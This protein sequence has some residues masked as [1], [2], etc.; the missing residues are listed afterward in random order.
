MKYLLIPTTLILSSMPALATNDELI[1]IC[2]ELG[3]REQQVSS[4]ISNDPEFVYAFSGQITGS[5]SSD[6]YLSKAKRVAESMAKAKSH[7]YLIKSGFFSDKKYIS[8]LVN[9]EWKKDDYH[10]KVVC[11]EQLKKQWAYKAIDTIQTRSQID[12]LSKENAIQ[13]INEIRK[14]RG[15]DKR[16]LADLGIEKT[17]EIPLFDSEVLELCKI[18]G[19][20]LKSN[21]LMSLAF[22]PYKYQYIDVDYDLHQAYKSKEY[23]ENMSVLHDICY[24]YADTKSSYDSSLNYSANDVL[25]VSEAH[26]ATSNLEKRKLQ[27]Q[28]ANYES[29]RKAKLLLE[30]Q[31]LIAQKLKE[32]Q[33]NEERL[34]AQTKK[35]KMDAKSAE[36]KQLRQ[37]NAK[38]LSAMNRINAIYNNHSPKKSMVIISRKLDDGTMI[39]SVD[40]TLAGVQD[41]HGIINNA[42]VYEL[43]V[44]KLDNTLSRKLNNGFT[45]TI[46]IYGVSTKGQ[47]DYLEWQ[48]TPEAMA[49]TKQYAE[50]K[51]SSIELTNKIN[52]LSK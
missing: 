7:D 27:E 26:K 3:I 28:K 1:S 34:E 31:T 37:E 22:N 17:K 40:G 50:A 39:G 5:L 38:N 23:V 33:E 25:S 13:K 19:F 44:V 20:Y 24:A 29:T 21:D 41:F 52:E 12:A 11:E 9:G 4:Q 51:A 48:K 8:V 46:P 30:K 49:L 43:E 15:T 45:E 6:F 14:R 35:A 10:Q 36:I 47:Q 18:K 42:G 32:T 2:N 16:P